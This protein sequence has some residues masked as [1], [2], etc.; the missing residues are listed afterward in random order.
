[1]ALKVSGTGLDLG[2]QK[3]ISLADPSAGTDAATKQ[4]VDAAIRG[5]DWKPSVVAAAGSN[6]TTSGAQTIDGIAV[7]AGQRVLLTAQTTASQN[8]IWVVAAGAWT[9]PADFA[10]G[11][12][13]D[14]GIAVT[15]E[16]GTTYGGKVLM[17]T[18]ATAATITVDTTATTWSQ[19][20]GGTAYT[21]G[22]GI[23]ITGASVAAKVVASG[24]LL[25]GASGLSVD[26]SLVP[27]KYAANVPSGST[28]PAIV[29]NLGTT[30]VT[31]S[32]YDISGAKPVLI[33]VEATITDA[34]TVTLTFASAPTTGQYR[35][36]VTG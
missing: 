22:N 32:V 29:H 34:N 11:S 4:Y 36:V 3:I 23:T 13:Q 14:S 7:T 25:V 8:G 18:G 31:V 17:V 30:D 24:G 12:T 5:L 21:A 35:A 15:V 28:T 33:L 20:G 9:R 19:L 27:N 26:R 6:V 10:A 1:M 2:G 16:E